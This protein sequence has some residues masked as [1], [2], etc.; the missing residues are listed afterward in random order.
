MLALEARYAHVP[1]VRR[2]PHRTQ[3]RA[4]FRRQRLTVCAA[5][6]PRSAQVPE[7]HPDIGDW[8]TLYDYGLDAVRKWPKECAP[9]PALRARAPALTVCAPQLQAPVPGGGVPQQ[10]GGKVQGGEGGAPRASLRRPGWHRG[11]SS[12]VDLRRCFPAAHAWRVQV[13]APPT[14]VAMP[15]TPVAFLFPGQGSQAVGMLQS[16]KDLPAVA[17]MLATAKRVL[18]YDLLSICVDGALRAA[19]CAAAWP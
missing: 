3:L 13:M 10:G 5:A 12:P 18:G 1:K 11:A 9:R 8:W 16:C 19:A 17:A 15:A 6:S 7:P 2:V 4:R 14:P